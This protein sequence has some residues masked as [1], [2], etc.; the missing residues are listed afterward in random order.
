MMTSIFAE[1]EAESAVELPF[2]PEWFGI[3][4]VVFFGLLLLT[5]VAF[6]NASNRH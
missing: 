4:G 1:A 2:A 5:T 6:K 3:A